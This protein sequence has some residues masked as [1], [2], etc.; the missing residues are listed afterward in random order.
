MKT[1]IIAAAVCV[2]LIFIVLF[3]LPPYVLAGVVA[4]ICAISAYEL[5]HAIGGRD[6]DRLRI[7]ATFSAALIP[8]GAYFDLTALV[9]P[10]VLLVLM[11]LLFMEAIIAFRTIRQ[12]KF[13]QIL[14]TIFGGAIVPLML[15]SLVN[16]KMM[17][18]GH[19]LVLLPVISAF[20]TD[21]GAYFTGM[22]IGKRKVF[23]NVS[24][25]KTVEGCIGGLAAGTVFI[26][27]YSVV[28][29]AATPHGIVFWAFFIYGLV[30]AL[31]TQLGD[32][33]FSLIKRE[34]D[35]KDYGRL[36][37]GH[38]GML[39]RFDSMVF[40]APAMYLLASAIPAVIVIGRDTFA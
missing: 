38:G 21:A 25:K 12:I 36:I 30:G 16:L 31:I 19:L 20:L 27:V 4:L 32:L 6:N 39:D 13:T 7:Y 29:L 1:R 35:V 15:S 34:F 5:L 26:M 9:F 3:F 33:A 17:P 37:P 23:P 40:A 8:V 2:P 11:S 10:A 28:L 18:E 14:T 24:P 22:A